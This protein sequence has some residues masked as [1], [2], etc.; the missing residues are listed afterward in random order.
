MATAHLRFPPGGT[1]DTTNV[2][3]SLSSVQLLAAN[4]NRVSGSVHNDTNSRMLVKLGATASTTSFTERVPA[5]ATYKLPPGYVG[6]VDAIWI[7]SAA[8]FARVTEVTP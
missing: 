7:S 8:G 1:P 3:A 2:A 4:A 5:R 6:R